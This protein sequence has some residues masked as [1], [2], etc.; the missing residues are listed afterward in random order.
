[1]E[2]KFLYYLYFCAQVNS[3]VFL[4]LA[5]FALAAVTTA[6]GVGSAASTE[7]IDDA[8]ASSHTQNSHYCSHSEEAGSSHGGR[9]SVGACALDAVKTVDASV[10]VL[11]LLPPLIYEASSSVDFYVFKCTFNS[12]FWLAAPG[13]ALS[14]VL[15]AWAFGPFGIDTGWTFSQSLTLGSILAATDPVS[16]RDAFSSLFSACCLLSSAVQ[17]LTFHER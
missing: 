13:V 7:L 12:I 5:G 6:A 2:S 3:N 16:V 11:V 9:W 15:H 8:E 4:F 17:A 14:A 1:M 10:F